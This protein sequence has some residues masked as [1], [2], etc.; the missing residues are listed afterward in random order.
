MDGNAELIRL[1]ELLRIGI[2]TVREIARH[3]PGDRGRL[4]DIAKRSEIMA[5]ELDEITDAHERHQ[6]LQ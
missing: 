3:R 1:T 4:L 2:T 6:K 5:A